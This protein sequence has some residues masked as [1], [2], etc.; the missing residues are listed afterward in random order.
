MNLKPLSLLILMCL[1]CLRLEEAGTDS[2]S[3]HA[4]VWHAAGQYAKNLPEGLVPFHREYIQSG[5]F[6]Q[7]SKVPFP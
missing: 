6:A 2:K 5:T 7:L 4:A 1:V 3:V